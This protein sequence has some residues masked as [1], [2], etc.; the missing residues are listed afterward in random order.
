[1]KEINLIFANKLQEL[2]KDSGYKQEVVAKAL[3]FSQQFYSK[4]EMGKTNF[5]PKIIKAICLFFNISV[6]NFL[7]TGNQ[8]KFIDSPQANTQNS[9]NND[10]KMLEELVKA[11]DETINSQRETILHQKELITELKDSN[12][13]LKK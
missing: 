1:M 13:K 6:A 5:S 7:N 4:L 12:N 11:K 3:K 2:R 9:F 8:T 10:T